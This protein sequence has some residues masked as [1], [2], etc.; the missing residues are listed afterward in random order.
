[1]TAIL[2]KEKPDPTAAAKARAAADRSPPK[3]LG[4]TELAA[5]LYE[6]SLAASKVGR[7][8]QR[9]A[10]ISKAVSLAEK[11]GGPLGQYLQELSFTEDN[12]GN[13]RNALKI[14]LRRAEVEEATRERLSHGTLGRIVMS[15]RQIGDMGQA[16]Q[17][18]ERLKERNDRSVDFCAG[19][20]QPSCK[21]MP[22]A[23]AIRYSIAALMLAAEGKFEE[24]IELRKNTQTMIDQFLDKPIAG[25]LSKDTYVDWAD[26]SLQ[27]SALLKLRAGRLLEAE[28]DSRAGLSRVLKTK[29][30]F[31]S[32]AG[33]HILSLHRII[34]EQGRFEDAEALALEAL[35]IIKTVGTEE[36]T[37]TMSDARAFVANSLVAQAE[38]K[39]AAGFYDKIERALQRDA[40]TRRSVLGDNLSLVW[41]RYRTGSVKPGIAGARSIFSAR[42]KNFGKSNYLT[43][44]SQGF[45]AMGLLYDGKISEALKEFRGATSV[46]LTSAQ[47][48]AKDR[49]KVS[50]R[51]LRLGAILDAYLELLGSAEGGK[52]AT[53]IG[54][55]A[56]SEAFRVSDFGRSRS[57]QSALAASGARA[58]AN[59]PAL[60]K[61]VRE[62]QDT[63][64]QIDG[65]F[66][67]LRNALTAPGDQ[68]DAK[69]IASLR[70]AIKALRANNKKLTAEIA[71]KFPSYTELIAPKPPTPESV[72][73][74]LAPGEALI[75]YYLTEKNAY[76]WAV[77]KTGPIAFAN[78]ALGKEDIGEMVDDL[79]EALDPGVGELGKIPDFNVALSHKL[80]K[81]LLAPVR[82][83]WKNAKSLLVVSHKSLSKIPL[84]VFVTKPSR[85]PKESGALFAKYKNIPWLAKTHT[86]TALPSVASL[87]SLRAR[88]AAAKTRRAFVGFGDPYFSVQQATAAKQ[89]ASVQVAASMRGALMRGG[90]VNLRSAPKS[91][92]VGNSELAKLP[93]LP[94]TG[95]EVVSVAKAL[96]ADQKRDVF[97]GTRATEEA[98]KQANLSDYK[99]L[100]FA[101]HGLI[102]LDLNGLTQPALA[103]SSPN[104]TAGTREDGLL[105]MG[106]ILTLKLDADWVVLSACNTAAGEE[107]GEAFSGLGRAFF[108]AG[109]RAILLSNW[110]VETT[111]ARALT[112]D[113]FKRQADQKNLSRSQALQAAMVSLINGEGYI[114]PKT[115]KVVFSYAHPIFWAPFS[116]VGDGGGGRPGA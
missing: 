10:D 39:A 38:W 81:S 108:Y 84:S 14:A 57:V 94:D 107:G 115:N 8:K 35:K 12:A 23:T 100:H 47:D 21:G 74:S 65:I 62:E 68:Q 77:P 28:I 69:S 101:T 87:V 48:S 45:L 30:K 90:R 116:L 103:L 98:V 70:T 82:R 63:Q 34:F 61:L 17:W 4:G 26:N 91:R 46:L 9:L 3:G 51:D 58:A 50:A 43:A 96:R 15:Y 19:S 67:I 53:Q 55:D 22:A 112:T 41:A 1:I 71:T 89:T 5:F 75:S 76:V 109:T 27:T 33:R 83:G 80:Y 25:H 49:S 56:V 113:L 105:T 92:G 79:R 104:L 73:K 99:V 32:Q 78:A 36:D 93:R 20:S 31:S 13:L 66:A 7:L 85:L 52:A 18:L 44:E 95:E 24:A 16:K 40:V 29:G 111:S 86:V 72:R 106:E 6:R 64:K 97:L 88:P 60:A 59:T 2:D 102:P 110:P 54:F 42:S 11:H 114:D 37:K